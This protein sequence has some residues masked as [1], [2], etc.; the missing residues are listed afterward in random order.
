MSFVHGKNTVVTVDSND[1][2]TWTNNSQITRGADEHDLTGYGK[3]THVVQGG[4][5]KH[6]FTMDGNYDSTTSTGPRA[7]LQP[8]VGTV[9]T[10]TR[11]PEGTGTG[12]PLESFSALLTEYVETN[13]VA[14]FVKWSAKFTV[15]DDISDSTQA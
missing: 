14:D 7:T 13:P 4:L 12:K 2:S 15:S 8:I 5:L 3:N 6:S 10:V 1:L 9:V 11:K